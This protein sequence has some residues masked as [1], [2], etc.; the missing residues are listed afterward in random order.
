MRTV[1]HVGFLLSPDWRLGGFDHSYGLD[2]FGGFACELLSDDFRGGFYNVAL[3]VVLSYV[4]Y[5]NIASCFVVF[6]SGCFTTWR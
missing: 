6:A 2:H 1:T 4:P 3:L 5:F